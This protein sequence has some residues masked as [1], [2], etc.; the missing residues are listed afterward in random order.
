MDLQRISTMAGK[1]LSCYWWLCFVLIL[2]CWSYGNTTTL[3]NRQ[4]PLLYEELESGPYAFRVNSTAKHF[5]SFDSK[6]GPPDLLVSDTL[7]N[8]GDTLKVRFEFSIDDRLDSTWLFLNHSE[9]TRS[10]RS[11]LRHLAGDS[12]LLILG[13]GDTTV[14]LEAMCLLAEPRHFIIQASVR[15][16]DEQSQQPVSGTRSFQP[17]LGVKDLSDFSFGYIRKEN[18][19]HDLIH[20]FEQGQL[21]AEVFNRDLQSRFYNFQ[22]T[23]DESLRWND[24]ERLLYYRVVRLH[25]DYLY[26]TR[27]PEWPVIP[28]PEDTTRIPVEPFMLRVWKSGEGLVA[29]IKN[30]EIEMDLALISSILATIVLGLTACFHLLLALG[31][32]L[33]EYAWGGGHKVLP[34]KLRLSSLSA[35]GILVLAG[36][37]VL[38]RGGLVAPG[39]EIL[40][41]RMATWGLSAYFALNTIGNLASKSSKERMVMS[42]ATA[43]LFAC[44]L[45]VALS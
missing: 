12:S 43:I 42:P 25:D 10:W 30:Q 11:P 16:V 35:V 20:R 5:N 41:V 28:E 4:G 18:R 7:F 27:Q 15:V 40:F 8:M 17:R 24:Y 13:A 6:Y 23:A 34:K 38:A 1:R 31:Q 29:N 9:I 36:W 3:V 21:S 39:P 26:R 19:L 37:V 33:G 22:V 32:P 45:L 2:F 44:F 14:I